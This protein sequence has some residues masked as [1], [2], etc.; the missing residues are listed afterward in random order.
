MSDL[1]RDDPRRLWAIVK[2]LVVAASDDE[3]LSY[4]GA[5]PLED[6]LSSNGEQFIELIEQQAV[7]DSRFRFCLAGVWRSGMT[8]EIWQRVIA[9]V[10]DRG[11]E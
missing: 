7:A 11:G 3:A 6:L 1:A 8:D 10:A 2:A 5:G 9:A 4:I